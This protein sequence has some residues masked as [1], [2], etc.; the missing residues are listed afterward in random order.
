MSIPH[1]MGVAEEE[2]FGW[3]AAFAALQ[4][5]SDVAPL[6]QMLRSK[7]SIP[8][9]IARKLARLLD[10]KDGRNS[11]VL[12]PAKNAR[13]TYRS[14]KDENARERILLGAKILHDINMGRGVE[15]AVTKQMRGDKFSRSY[16][17]DCR[18][19]AENYVNA[20]FTTEAVPQAIKILASGDLGIDLRFVRAISK[21]SAD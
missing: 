3:N 8:A 5:R 10:D 7:R 13:R 20:I 14:K 19:V 15:E 21:A 4:E 12:K 9:P 18:L 16:L 11:V 6:V 17:Y 1:F 2:T